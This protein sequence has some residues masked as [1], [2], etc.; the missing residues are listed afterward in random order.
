MYAGYKNRKIICDEACDLLNTSFK[1]GLI[2]L[3]LSFFFAFLSVPADQ[4]FK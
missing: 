4:N 3:L 1:Y 2:L